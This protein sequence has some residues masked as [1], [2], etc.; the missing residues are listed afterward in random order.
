[1]KQILEKKLFPHVIK[2]GRYTGGEI[3]Q[4]V[5]DPTGKTKYLHAFPDKYELGQSYLGLQTLYHVVNSDDRFLCERVFAVDNDAEEIMRRENIPLFSLESYRP[6]IEFDAIGFTLPYEMILTNFL[7]ML[8][9]AEIPLRTSERTESDPIIMA[10]GPAVYNPEPMANFIDLFFIGDAEEGLIEILTIIHSM[11]DASRIKKLE[12]IVKNVKSVYVPAF[13]DDS[14]NPINEFA[15]AKIEGRIEKEL[16]PNYYPS[17]PIVPLIETTHK[18][19]SVEIM[20]GCPQG[21]R[22]CQA[23][24]M[25]RP[26]RIRSQEDVTEQINT[27]YANSGYEEITL[28]SLSSTDYPKIDQLA[29]SISRKLE[30]QKVSITLPSLRP[31]SIS[32]LL[33]DA[34]KRVRTSGLTISPEAGTER[35]RKFIRKDFPD[36][37]VYDTVRLAFEKGWTTLKFYFMVGLPTETDE[38]LIGI[39]QMLKRCYDIGSSHHGKKIFNVTLSPFIP[40][41]HTPFQWDEIV[42]P[43]E[44]L[45]RIMFVKNKNRINQ[46]NFKYSTIETALLQGLIGRGGRKIGDVIFDVFKNGGRF[47]GWNENFDYNLWTEA[48]DK[49]GIS[50]DELTKPISFDAELPWSHIHKGISVEHLKNERQRT[51]TQLKD[52]APHPKQNN[53]E[54]QEEFISFGRSKKKAPSRQVIAPTKNKIRIRWGKSGRYRYMGHLD[55]LRLIERTIRMAELPVAYSQGFNPTMKISFGPPLPLGFTSEAEL[56]EITFN[57]NFTPNMADKFRSKLPDG[58][59][60]YDTKV[61]LTKAKSLS[62]QLNRASYSVSLEED[63]D[64][65]LLID[66][67]ASILKLE[68]I[69]VERIGKETVRTIDIRPAIYNLKIENKKLLMILG[70][71]EGGYAKPNE[72]LEILFE[73]KFDRALIFNC[74]RVELFKIDDDGNK[75][76]AMK[77]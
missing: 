21:C 37:A 60:I 32:P 43:K 28:L 71:G 18:H 35:L 44:I 13:Y 73:H 40:K 65:E 19:L 36:E 47:D 16:K 9:L 38:D 3:G 34:V 33:F 53:M 69:E 14:I 64:T 72:L 24:P 55:N 59:D 48:F 57:T 15:P 7:T 63:V 12:E 26:V 76:E 39:L 22:F 74:H 46:I 61:V 42:S 67:I 58:I 25:Y 11:P 23:G 75:I 30:K 2:P 41:P 50:I 31:G 1:M 77:I 20:R 49:T 68:S 4:I 8:D 70:I 56:L 52:H 10:G 5:K 45:R 54:T 66:R 51:S 6:A 17:Q 27:Q 29:S 62:S